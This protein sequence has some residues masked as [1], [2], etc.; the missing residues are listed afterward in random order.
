[1]QVFLKVVLL[2]TRLAEF[3]HVSVFVEYTFGER[4]EYLCETL[5]YLIILF[6]ARRKQNCILMLCYFLIFLSAK[7]FLHF[8]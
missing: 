7:K 5:L 8:L 3:G 1:M 2:A 4:N 6:I